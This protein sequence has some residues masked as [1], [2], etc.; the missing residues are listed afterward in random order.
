MP[1]M[2]AYA[3]RG[4]GDRRED[5]NAPSRTLSSTSNGS[6]AVRQDRDVPDRAAGWHV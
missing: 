1:H 5:S 3:R 6:P 2:K 4:Q